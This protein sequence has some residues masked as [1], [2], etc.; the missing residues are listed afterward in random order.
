MGWRGWA[1]A[2][3]CAAM[4]AGKAPVAKPAP[5]GASAVSSTAPSGGASPL[6]VQPESRIR[7]WGLRPL[8]GSEPLE[9]QLGGTTRAPHSSPGRGDLRGA[10]PLRGSQSGGGTTRDGRPSKG[11][12]DVG[13]S[14]PTGS[15][16]RE[17][18]RTRGSVQST[19][20]QIDPD[21]AIVEASPSGVRRPTEQ[22][23]LCGEVSPLEEHPSG[24]ATS[25]RRLRRSGIREG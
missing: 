17:G 20:V 11:A 7:L 8:G 16:I 18:P 23:R 1:G 15:R 13:E 4:I 3:R 9:V 25:A 2:E 19:V 6:G 24:E 21:E 14:H 22:V 5:C 12:S 10:R